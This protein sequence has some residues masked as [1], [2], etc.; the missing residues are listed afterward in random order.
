V[1]A[2]VLLALHVATGRIEAS[3][4]SRLTVTIDLNK[5]AIHSVVLGNFGLRLP[6]CPAL[7]RRMEQIVDLHDCLTHSFSEYL[8]TENGRYLVARFVK[9]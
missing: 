3:F 4:A 6:Q 1:F 9:P 7:S 5:P 8:S 2:D